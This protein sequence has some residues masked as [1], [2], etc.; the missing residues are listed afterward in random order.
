MTSIS[1]TP[2]HFSVLS[3]IPFKN[4]TPTVVNSAQIPN[5]KKK[6]LR[7]RNNFVKQKSNENLPDQ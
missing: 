1:P 7:K 2:G 4:K 6:K 5:F 3:P